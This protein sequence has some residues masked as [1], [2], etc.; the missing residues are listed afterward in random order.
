MKYLYIVFLLLLP[1]VIIGQTKREYSLKFDEKDFSYLVDDG[2]MKII[3]KN[4][5]MVL[6]GDTIDPAMPYIGVNILISP[7]EDYYTIET[8]YNEVLVQT[9]ALVEPNP[10]PV[11]TNMPK[12]KRSRSN[13]SY[14][15]AVYPKGNV[16][17]TGTHLMDGYKYLSFVVCPFRYDALRG[18]LYLMTDINLRLQLKQYVEKEKVVNSARKEPGR[19]MR[20]T[21]KKLI[22][23]GEEMEKFY[24]KSPMSVKSS[25]SLVSE[26]YKYIIVTNETLRPAFEKLA[27]WK[28]IKGVR[29]KVVTV[30]DCY[31]AYHDSTPQLAIKYVLDNYYN[32]GMEYALLGGDTDVVPAQICYLPEHD[33]TTDTPTDLFYA[34]RDSCFSWDG[35]GNGIYG[36]DS[37]HVDLDPEFI[38][39]RTSVSNLAEAEVFV[40]RIIEYESSPKLEGWTNSF[41]SCGNEMYYSWSV[42]GVLMSD[43][44]MQGENVYR[45]A[46]QNYW[47]GN[48]FELF[49]TYSNHS[50]GANYDATEDHIQ[51]EL[52]KG[53]TF[54]DEFSHGWVNRWG[55][56]EDS[57]L[58]KIDKAS[59]LVNNSYT[60]ITTIAC[61]TNA[62]DKKSTD[63][64]DETDYY[65]TCLSEAF[66]RNPNSGI[67]AYFG[68]S[69]DGW[70]ECSS[71]FDEMF[72]KS[73][74]TGND[75][76]FGRAAMSSKNAFSSMATLPYENIE[77]NYRKLTMSLNPIGD[78]E[79]PI[80]TWTPQSFAN[81]N[82]NF[83]NGTVNVT[84]GVSDCRIC[85]SSASDYGNSYYELSDSTN[86]ATFSGVNDDCF[87]CIT[88]TGYIPYLA[89][90]GTSVFLQN[91][92]IK[93]DLRVFSTTTDA[94]SNVTTLK[95]QGPVSIEKGKLSVRSQGNVTLKNDFEVKLGAELEILTP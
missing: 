73:L 95:P 35:N 68:S 14:K 70:I 62:F 41:L 57:T 55:W 80:F 29:A 76:Q 1:E 9:D 34:C 49:D 43:A 50:N 16:V 88:K 40:N 75:K 59:N 81:V 67:L 11:P 54:V 51:N 24:A 53:Y 7:N 12:I 42:L 21:V 32:S 48:L 78:P 30:E 71:Q 89:R 28:T 69:R 63:F 52:E 33:K 82:I 25:S 5:N 17:F 85:V 22:I 10:I 77:N 79:M 31:E 64:P 19:N 37:D 26:P 93:S 58:Y 83:S 4:K 90:V 45:N 2:L 8:D 3:S 47:S 15:E 56:L 61:Y 94:G 91:E 86:S 23:N 72:Y 46:V 92:T 66:I 6:W 20:N 65:T 74:F 84:T 27:R 36:E 60:V 39:T 44:Q 87:V 13:I 38:I 18:Y